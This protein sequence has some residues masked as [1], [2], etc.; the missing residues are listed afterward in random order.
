ML[1]KALFL[2]IIKILSP[3]AYIKILMR[4]AGMRLKV[5]FQ[6]KCLYGGL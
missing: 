6:P 3:C 1:N 5:I 4:V 2:F